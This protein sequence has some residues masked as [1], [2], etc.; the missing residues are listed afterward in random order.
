MKKK[1]L[2]LIIILISAFALLNFTSCHETNSGVNE[3]KQSAYDKVLPKGTI[4]VGYIPYSPAIIKDP[5]T[6]QISGIFYDVMMEVGKNLDLKVEFEEELTFGTMVEAVKTNKVDLVSTAVYVKSQRGKFVDFTVPLYYSPLKTFVRVGNNKFD[7]NLSLINSPDVKIAT[8]DGEAV[9][10]LAKTDFPKAQAVS[11]T[12]SSDVSQMLEEV[13]SGK[14]DVTFVEPVFANIY[15]KNNPNK[16]REVTGVEPVRIY[17]VAMMVGRDDGKFLA[18]LNIAIE[19]LHLNGF[20]EKT[21]AKY[22][23]SSNSFY[24]F[25]QPYRTK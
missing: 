4:R 12:Q 16:I 11:L 21:I 17:P 20:V 5:N 6:K 14:A 24:R 22:E 9:S 1:V 23:P 13:A 10:I 2:S 19:E 25:Q 15:I 8:I 3:T 7:N 18:M